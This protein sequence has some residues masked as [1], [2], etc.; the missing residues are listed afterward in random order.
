MAE[1]EVIFDP[2][3]NLA[4]VV[5]VDNQVGWGPAMIGPDAGSILEAWIDTTPFDMSDLGSYQARDL[6]RSFLSRV[7]DSR[8]GGSPPA[9]DVAKAEPGATDVVAAR[10]AD[11]E[12]AAGGGEPPPPAPADTDVEADTGATPAT[13]KCPNCKGTG[14]THDGPEGVA[15][16][17]GMCQGS[18][19]VTVGVPAA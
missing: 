19:N 4:A 12:A 13:M 18:G 3:K 2:V 14:Q 15:A 8:G 5:D 7:Q 9:G 1:L 17:C 10:S 16:Q 6:F 11:A